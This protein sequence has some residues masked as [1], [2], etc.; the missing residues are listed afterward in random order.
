MW[1]FIHQPPDHAGSHR[2]Y[3]LGPHDLTLIYCSLPYSIQDLITSQWGMKS[4]K[5]DGVERKG[6]HIP[7]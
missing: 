2:F 5:Y 6:T 3:L 7:S 4:G 1:V